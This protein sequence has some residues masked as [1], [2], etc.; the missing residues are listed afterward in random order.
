MHTHLYP[1]AHTHVLPGSTCCTHILRCS[2]ELT[3]LRGHPVYGRKKFSDRKQGAPLRQN[4][5]TSTPLCHQAIGHP[6][7]I[8]MLALQADDRGMSRLLK[9]SNAAGALRFTDASPRLPASKAMHRIPTACARPE[10]MA[11]CVESATR[12]TDTQNPRMDAES[13]TFLGLN[14]RLPR[15]QCGRASWASR[16]F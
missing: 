5:T 16:S 9:S 2:V 15:L 13:V 7:A 14:S 11:R 6:S 10:G 3:C 8:V 1:C 4:D 12:R